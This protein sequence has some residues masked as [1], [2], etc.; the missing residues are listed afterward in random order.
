MYNTN[1]DTI[2]ESIKFISKAKSNP[3]YDIDDI[4]DQYD[5]IKDEILFS[6]D[7]SS[8]DKDILLNALEQS[9]GISK[10]VLQNRYVITRYG[11]ELSEKFTSVEE[12]EKRI[13]EYI[14]EAIIKAE[15]EI[16]YMLLDLVKFYKFDSLDALEI[17]RIRKQAYKEPFDS[18]YNYNNDTD[19]YKVID[20]VTGDPVPISVD[21]DE[22][23]LYKENN[24]IIKKIEVIISMT[25]DI[26]DHEL[27]FPGA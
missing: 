4:I 26:V 16:H 24:K 6:D 18:F 10:E 21:V 19:G 20:R 14:R 11:M 17:R 7:I 23:E 22:C 9:L 27:E 15:Y 25:D 13:T 8:E 2:N 5:I 12:A 3:D 1:I